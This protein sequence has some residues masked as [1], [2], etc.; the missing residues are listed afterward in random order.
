VIERRISP[1]ILP[2]ADSPAL[3][4]SHAPPSPAY[5]FAH[6][7]AAQANTNPTNARIA[8]N[9]IACIL[10]AD[11]PLAAAIRQSAELRDRPLVLID[12]AG[13]RDPAGVS[14]R[15]PLRLAARAVDGRARGNDRG[16]GARGCCRAGRDRP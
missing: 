11:F 9:R 6:P 5:G 8:C 4:T 16:A 14:N 7:E 12:S 2:G 3:R 10:V 1:K 15:M 13:R